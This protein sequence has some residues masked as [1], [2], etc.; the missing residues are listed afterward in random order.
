MRVKFTVKAASWIYLEGT[1][2]E[3]SPAITSPVIS[4]YANPQQGAF[5]L[6]NWWGSNFAL[7]RLTIGGPVLRTGL[8]EP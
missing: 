5:T 7:N 1:L 4:T 6:V 8:A 3:I 2:H